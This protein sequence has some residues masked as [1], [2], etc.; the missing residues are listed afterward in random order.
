MRGR[1]GPG[2][3]Q[4]LLV[5]RAPVLTL[6]AS[7]VA[8]RLGY[9]REEALSLG[10]AVAG[11]YAQL[12]GR[13]LGLLQP[14]PHPSEPSAP[15]PREQSIVEL[16]SRP[17]PVTQ[18]REGVRVVVKGQ[19]IHPA[20]VERYLQRAFG[21]LLASARQA[22]A[23]LVASYAPEDLNHVAYALYERFRPEIPPGTRG[24]GVK[25]ALDLQRIRSLGQR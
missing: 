3:E 11:L 19:P 8:E 14:H 25:G 18:T 21:A 20:S 4:T 7:V 1:Q 6:W 24:W 16:L 22:M 17:I 9:R 13:K 2:P 5:N 12:K 10:K 23:E 15:K